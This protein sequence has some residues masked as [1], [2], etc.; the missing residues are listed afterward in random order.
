[1]I[2]PAVT[3]DDLSAHSE[4]LIKSFEDIMRQQ[5][6]AAVA[7][8]IKQAATDPDVWAAMLAAI[9]TQAHQNA[10]SW[11]F[12]GIRQFFSKAAWF[13]VIGLAIYLVGGWSGL[14]S[15]FKTVVVQS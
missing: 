6:P 11:L 2:K 14:V 13:L 4:E 1:M 10:G 9:R 3:A 12:G 5:M 15:F 8:G 7:A